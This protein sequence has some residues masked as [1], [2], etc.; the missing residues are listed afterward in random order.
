MVP[1]VV[2]TRIAPSAPIAGI[3]PY[4]GR[5]SCEDI[6]SSRVSIGIRRRSETVCSDSGSNP[7]SA[8]LRWYQGLRAAAHSHWRRSFAS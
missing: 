8:N 1:D 3:S 2:C 5:T 6:Q 4:G 7:A